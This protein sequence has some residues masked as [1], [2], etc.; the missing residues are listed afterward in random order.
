[1]QFTMI[2]SPTNTWDVLRDLDEQGLAST[3]LLATFL[4]KSV[5]WKTH[6]KHISAAVAS[7]DLFSKWVEGETN[8]CLNIDFCLTSDHLPHCY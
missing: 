4:H 7:F 8:H 2:P 3:A 1:M 6:L 5:E